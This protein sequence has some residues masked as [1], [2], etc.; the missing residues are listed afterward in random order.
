MEEKERQER[1]AAFKKEYGELVQ[2]YQMDISSYPVCI[3]GGKPGV[4][5]VTIQ[6]NLVDLSE[7][8]TESPFIA[9]E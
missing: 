2:K 6:S 1:G 7:Q 3:P 8:P 5:E 4:F 9:K